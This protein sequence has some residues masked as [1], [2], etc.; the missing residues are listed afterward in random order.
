[1]VRHIKMYVM[2]V[3][4]FFITMAGS[5]HAYRCGTNLIREGDH[6]F[7]VIRKCGEPVLQDVIGYTL[8]T[9]GNRELVI[10]KWVYGPEHG[11]YTVLIFTGGV[12]TE[13]QLIRD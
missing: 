4:C 5:S 11:F 10:E 13:I 7:D 12:L 8:T 1:M 3:V 6:R 9:R 2:C